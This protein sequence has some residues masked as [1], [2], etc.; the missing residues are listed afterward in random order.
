[1][2]RWEWRL[3]YRIV[4]GVQRTGLY[5]ECSRPG[6][7]AVARTQESAG[8]RGRPARGAGAFRIQSVELSR[9]A[10]TGMGIEWRR[11][12]VGW[13]GQACARP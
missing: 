3:T 6:E 10:L 9:C 12:G 1:M 13:C 5:P 11:G 4:S 8:A 2:N 7:W